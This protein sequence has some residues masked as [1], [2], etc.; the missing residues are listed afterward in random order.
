MS[1]GW[2]EIGIS[3]D[4]RTQKAGQFFSLFKR[5]W[6]VDQVDQV[7]HFFIQSPIA[8]GPKN[9]IPTETVMM[10]MHPTKTGMFYEQRLEVAETTG[11]LPQML[12][13]GRATPH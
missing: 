11:A 7:D 2:V 4:S 13:H 12:K 1:L 5:C 10:V 9:E 8:T 6:E 3:R